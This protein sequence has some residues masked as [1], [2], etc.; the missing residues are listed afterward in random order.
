M[1]AKLHEESKL[2]MGESC[3]FRLWTLFLS[4]VVFVVLWYVF[5]GLF[6]ARSWVAILLA[7][8]LVLPVACLLT[9]F[10]G[11]TFVKAAM[12]KHPEMFAS[13]ESKIS[14]GLSSSHDSDSGE[15]NA[16]TRCCQLDDE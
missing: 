3:L 15:S 12:M 9:L 8:I 14:P 1:E 5:H 7:G 16:S 2:R 4:C 13:S 10:V 11:A 6:G